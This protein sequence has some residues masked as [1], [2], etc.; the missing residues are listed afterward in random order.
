M[1]H[2][3]IFPRGSNSTEYGGVSPSELIAEAEQHWNVSGTSVLVAWGLTAIGSV[4]SS[5]TII[6][7][8]LMFV[9]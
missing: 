3:P 4:S 8:I 1:N 2:L 5:Y 9:S 6:A 7:D